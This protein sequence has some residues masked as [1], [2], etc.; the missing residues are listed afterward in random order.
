MVVRQ[1]YPWVGGAERQAEQLAAKLIEQGLD[2][3]VVTGW[4][5]WDTAR[6][7]VVSGVPVFRNFT[8]WNMFGVRGL[9]KFAGYLYMLSLFWH[10]WRQRAHYDIIHVH[11]LSY[12]AWPAVLA[13]RWLGKKTII[14]LANSGT[15]SD[16]LRMRQDDMLPGQRWM[17]PLT[18]QAD[19]LVG[20]SHEIVAELRAAGVPANR[21]SHIPNGVVIPP[22]VPRRQ[23]AG[24]RLEVVFVGRLVPSKG[25]RTLIAAFDQARQA[26]PNLF[27]Q[28]VLLGSGPLRPELEAL[29]RSLGIESQVRFCGAVR[30]VPEHLRQADIFVLPSQAEG[31]SNALLE[32]MA[33][34]LPCIASRVG[35]NRDL[36][37]EGES[38]LLVTPDD[39]GELALALIRLAEDAALRE[40]LGR[41]ARRQVE[42]ENGLDSVARR[43]QALYAALW[44][45]AQAQMAMSQPAETR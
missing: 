4:W 27:G 32:A 17:L 26:R 21:I 11:L 13:G 18:L 31:I 10:L 24:G 45:E 8:F 1:F 2:V 38:G 34:G 12:P 16:L 36:I 42:A 35:G 33:R 3:R 20:I 40:R 25:G 5:R 28:L 41:Q 44:P 6:R 19:R 14:K 43:Y 39:V 22:A 37:R 30:D 9:R 7:E 23:P 29:A 15:Q